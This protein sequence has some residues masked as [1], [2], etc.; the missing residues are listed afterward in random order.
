MQALKKKRPNL[1]PERIIFHQDHAP[2]HRAESTPLEIS[3][4]GFE[5]LVHPPYCPSFAPIG[6]H[7]FP[8]IKGKL[9]GIRFEDV[10]ELCMY[11]QNVLSSYT[12]TG[13]A[14]SMLNGYGDI[15]NAFKFVVITLK[16]YN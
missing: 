5:L 1:N 10:N 12:R 9:R 16:N 13:L 11:T 7:V 15:E 8:E 6:I 2:G 4:L 14:I 3:L